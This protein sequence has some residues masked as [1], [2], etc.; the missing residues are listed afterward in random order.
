MAQKNEEVTGTVEGGDGEI[1][2][3]GHVEVA[4]PT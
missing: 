4:P 2:G 1:V 3:E